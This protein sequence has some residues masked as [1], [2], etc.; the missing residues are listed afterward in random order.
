MTRIVV[1]TDGSE[2]ATRAMRW[3]RDEARV[4]D[5]ELEVVLA[6]GLLDQHHADRSDRF[7]GDYGP[8][9]AQATLDAWVAETYGDGAGIQVTTRVECDLPA[10]ALLEAG[11][12]ADLVVVGARGSGGFEGLLLGSVSERV[13][14][15]AEG[16]VA[17]IRNAAPV[18]GGRVVVG[19]D[20]SARSRTA[21]RWAAAEARARGAEL[22]VV[23]AW[24]LP[25]M[26]ASPFLAVY[27]TRSALEQVARTVLDTALA[28]PALADLTVQGHL[29]YG[30]AARALLE[31]SADAGLLV[32]GT[33]G[34]G[35][36]AG[37]LLGSVTRQ[38][39]HH[40]TCPVVVL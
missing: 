20:G 35:R 40:A 34:L 1:G 11:Q 29:V 14:Q 24:R 36:V 39:L 26:T 13:A 25:M 16:P 27:P 8:D 17:V 21:M 9:A 22:D 3:A 10:R 31:R 12:A 23:H 2:H 19:I 4:H 32:A 38:L 33:R 15:L 6:W 37:T 5:A 18:Q 28:D 7:D 30:S